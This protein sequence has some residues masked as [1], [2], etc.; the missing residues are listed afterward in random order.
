MGRR[1]DLLAAIAAVTAA[2]MLTVYVVIMRDQG[3][4][5]LWWV[6][7]TLGLSVV[8]CGFAVDRRRAHRRGL[9]G[10]AGAVLVVL[11]VLS[12]LSIGCPILIAGVTALIAAATANG[13]PAA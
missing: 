1:W 3:D 12:L 7:A 13:R 10:F 11:G 9:L 6:L 4:T 8:L 5:P 2:V